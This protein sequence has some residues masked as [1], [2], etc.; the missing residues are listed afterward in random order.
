VGGGA[1]L[2]DD[3]EDF[4]Y[5][6]CRPLVLEAKR[7]VITGRR[8]DGWAADAFS[9]DEGDDN[10]R[11]SSAAARGARAAA[12]RERDRRARLAKA[13]DSEAAA[14]EV[15]RQRLLR[16]SHE[17]LR[18]LSRVLLSP[19]G[20]GGVRADERCAEHAPSQEPRSHRPTAQPGADQREGDGEGDGEDMGA[21]L[22]S[23]T[24]SSRPRTPKEAVAASL[25]FVPRRRRFTHE[26]I[27]PP[28][29]LH[30]HVAAVFNAPHHLVPAPPP[31]APPGHSAPPS[32]RRARPT[33]ANH[34]QH[35]PPGHHPP[36]HP[37]MGA[38]PDDGKPAGPCAAHTGG[39]DTWG[40]DT[41]GR[42][43]NLKA[44]SRPRG[45]LS[46]SLGD[47][48]TQR[49]ALGTAMSACA[50]APSS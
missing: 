23:P 16:N 5:V 1:S 32:G 47:A 34:P 42:P 46:A 19:L 14:L 24:G 15:R 22:A 39:G 9:D 43:L 30:P 26:G 6:A 48:H 33:S 50:A 31:H 41:W 7:N 25:G 45:G 10:P 21:P 27:V 20:R 49:V 44:L 37:S 17:L 12:R 13:P 38:L 8:A 11:T 29:S 4:A 35:H 18:P 28:T 36:G 40:G 2:S 3:E